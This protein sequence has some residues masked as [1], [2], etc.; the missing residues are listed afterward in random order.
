MRF[1][2]TVYERTQ[3][4]KSLRLS[5]FPAIIPAIIAAGCGIAG[6]DPGAG[7]IYAIASCG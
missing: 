4:Q 1:S 5:L 3:Y 2:S 6:G 7:Q